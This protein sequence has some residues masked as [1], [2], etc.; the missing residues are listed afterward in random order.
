MGQKMVRKNRSWDRDPTRKR[1]RRTLRGVIDRA[2][3]SGCLV[4]TAC[5]VIGAA[6][7]AKDVRPGSARS[8][9]KGRFIQDGA[10]NVALIKLTFTEGQVL[11]RT[12]FALGDD[13]AALVTSTSIPQHLAFT[14]AAAVD[15]YEVFFPGGGLIA[16]KGAPT[17]AVPDHVNLLR[18][19][20][21]PSE[22]QTRIAVM[23]L[24]QTPSDVGVTGLP[25]VEFAAKATPIDHRRQRS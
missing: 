15:R 20:T 12:G 1:E 25:N 10:R 11:E 6:S 13:V 9:V 18:L 5:L 21:N 16:D 17:F 7:C 22:L 4:A 8:S 19:D 14:G 24:K 23:L 2:R 3:H